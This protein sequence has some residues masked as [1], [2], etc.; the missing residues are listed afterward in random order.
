MFRVAS[1]KITVRLIVMR[2][3]PP[4]GKENSKGWIWKFVLNRHIRLQKKD[5]KGLY[6]KGFN[7]FRGSLTSALGT[8]YRILTRQEG[9]ISQQSNGNSEY[10]Q[11]ML[12]KLYRR[13]DKVLVIVNISDFWL[14]PCMGLSVPFVP[15]LF[16]IYFPLD[17]IF[18]LF[19]ILYSVRFSQ[20]KM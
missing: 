15:C 18:I 7:I 10:C 6:V 11:H 12:I 3:T 17:R 1:T 19:C 16:G 5:F 9:N 13:F 14:S 20:I 8:T 4:R 2:T